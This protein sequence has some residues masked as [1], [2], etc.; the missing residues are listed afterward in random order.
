MPANHS[1]NKPLQPL[2][3][4]L[5]NNSTAAESRLW[6]EVLRKGQLLGYSFL[7]QRPI[8]QYIA[9]FVCKQLKLVIEVD[10]IT[11]QW[12][13]NV[14][15][16]EQKDKRLQELGFTVLRFTDQQVTDQLNSVREF[17]VE[18]IEGKRRCGR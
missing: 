16:D 2:A 13:E 3:R 15:R 6:C 18:W 8:D 14:Q 5:R 11:H 4:Q 10:G 1:Y 7:R 17:L 9:D 12:E